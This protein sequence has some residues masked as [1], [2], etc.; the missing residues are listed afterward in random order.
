MGVGEWVGEWGGGRVQGRVG[1]WG[2]G[3]V[4]AREGGCKG[5]WGR[6]GGEGGE[7]GGSAGTERE[8]R[9]RAPG[10]KEARA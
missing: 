2:G 9:A 3:R 4:G 10:R 7:G 8:M 6:E 1:E 5:G